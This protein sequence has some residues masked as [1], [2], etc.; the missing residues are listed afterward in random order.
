MTLNVPP[1]VY[2][3][4]G[5]LRSYLG[6]P[7][8]AS[9]DDTQLMGFLVRASRAID[10]YCRRHFYPLYHTGNSVLKFDIPKDDQLRFD[11]DLLA[12]N[13]LSDVGGASGIAPSVYWLKCGDDWNRTPYD[14]VVLDDSS[15]STFNY[16]GTPRRAIWADVITGYHEDYSR[17][18]VNSGASLTASMTS[19]QQTIPVSGSTGPNN[20][21]ISPRFKEYG[22]I[23]RIGSEIMFT[24]ASVSAS[25]IRV[26]RGQNGTTAAS[27]ASGVT[28]ETWSPEEDIAFGALRLAAMQYHQ[29]DTPYTGRTTSVQFGVIESQDSWPPDVHEKLRRYVRHTY[30]GFS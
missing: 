9:Q 27:H 29:R 6:L 13:G 21:G 7:S 20:I 16:S 23:V 2:A 30:Y 3:T 15:G 14:R 4:L 19:L 8:S 26:I 1:N 18:W 12:V 17:A 22:Q 24:A 5:D 10:R 28:V 25:S 11:H